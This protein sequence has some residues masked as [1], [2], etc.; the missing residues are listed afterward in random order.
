ME[1]KVTRRSF[2][3]GSA[4]CLTAGALGPGW[5]GDLASAAEGPRVLVVLQLTGG[6]DGLNTVVPFKEKL[7][8]ELRPGLALSESGPHRL[9]E[10]LALHPALAGLKELWDEGMLAVINGCGYPDPNRSHF[11]AMRIWHTADPKLKEGHGW[12]G[13]WLDSK[14]EPS[15]VV[16]LGLGNRKSDALSAQNTSVPTFASIEDIASMAGDNDLSG[17]LREMQGAGAGAS[18]AAMNSALDAVSI[19]NE[20]LSGFTPRQSYPED[21]FGQGL[22][23]AARLIAVSPATRVLYLTAGGFDTHADQLDQHTKLMRGFGDGVR[24]FFSEMDGIGKTNEVALVA[25]SEFGRRVKENGSSGTD[26]GAAGPMFV[27]GGGVRGGLYGEYPSLA[28]LERG[29][30]QFNIDFRRVYATLIGDWLGADPKE[31]LKGDFGRIGLFS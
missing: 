25:F 23:A 17:L 31:V 27:I 18:G 3:L 9:E 11:S 1:F 22:K 30:L 21:E 13:R 4:A 12:L 16:G 8:R 19:L 24:A 26:H 14:D 20:N 29:D 28:K 2:L 7:Y 10:G 15:P 5:L 6:N